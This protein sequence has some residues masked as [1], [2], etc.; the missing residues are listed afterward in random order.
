MRVVI[1]QVDMDTCLAAFV[2]GVSNQ[3]QIEMVQGGAA[4]ED[5]ADPSV[6]CIEAGG[7]GQVHLN[8]FDHHDTPLPL[9]PACRQALTAAGRIDPAICRLVDYAAV[10]DT[11]GPSALPRSPEPGFPTLS[12]VF[13]GM[14]FFLERDPKE[15]L[16]AGLAI[17]GTVVEQ[18][19]DPFGLIPER[20]EWGAFLQA[21]RRERDAIEWVKAEAEIFSARSGRR[22]GF[23]QTDVKEAPGAL[24]G[25]GCEIAVAYSPRFTPPS[26]GAPICKYTIAGNNG[27]RVDHLLPHLNALDPGWGGPAHGTIIGSPR[28]GTP[29]SPEAVKRIVADYT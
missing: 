3:D 15:Q 13:S 23:L 27:I 8:N 24:Y 10:L 2:L 9:P 28:R 16:R 12:S 17:L 4:P 22:V 6:L 7:S 19:I 20:P 14:R 29:L 18:G 1:Q 21:K 11:A 25:L 26:G 5:L